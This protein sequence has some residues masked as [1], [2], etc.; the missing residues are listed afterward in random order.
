MLIDEGFSKTSFPPIFSWKS[1][2]KT[3]IFLSECFSCLL[4]PAMGNYELFPS[5]NL[6]CKNSL[7]REIHFAAMPAHPAD[8]GWA[9]RGSRRERHRTEHRPHTW[10]PA[11]KL[12]PG[13]MAFF[14]ILLLLKALLICLHYLHFSGAPGSH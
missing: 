7:Q 6:S 5:V 1:A 10:S 9:S 12:Q 14:F 11:P 13:W 2:Q 3:E 8:S 4:L